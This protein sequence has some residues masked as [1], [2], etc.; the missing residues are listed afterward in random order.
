MFLLHSN[1]YPSFSVYS[2]KTLNIKQVTYESKALQIKN[3]FNIRRQSSNKEKDFKKILEVFLSQNRKFQVPH[4]KFFHRPNE[5]TMD[6]LNN[7]RI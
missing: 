6:C 1:I 3:Y 5:Y 4:T 2:S 7:K